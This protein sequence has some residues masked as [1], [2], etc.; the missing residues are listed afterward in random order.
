MEPKQS[1]ETTGEDVEAAVAAGLAE[2]GV[3]PGDVLVEVL[4]EPSRGVFGIGAKPAR[5][6]LQ[7]LRPPSPTPASAPAAAASR[8]D[9]NLDDVEDDD[10]TDMSAADVV[11]D[12]DLE[13]DATVGREVLTE[14]LD[15]LDMPCE[16]V[17]RRSE[18]TRAGEI[19]PWLLD[20]QGPSMSLLIGRRGETLTS[21]QY[22][23]RLITSRRLQRR[24]N[25]VV[26]A[27]GYKLRRSQRLRQLALRMADQAVE[28]GRAVSLEPMPPNERR[29]IHLALRNHPH[30][31]TQSMGEGAARKVTIVPK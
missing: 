23:T 18:S 26:D 31:I 10:E 21:L 28:H 17:I 15:K 5:V 3:G 16:I 8:D 20:I 9:D 6:R 1:V 11:D 13:E 22:I 14:L 25:I 19:A 2:L 30:V 27:G 7:L 4:D 24:A 12:S 29:I